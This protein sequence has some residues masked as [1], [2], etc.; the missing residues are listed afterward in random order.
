ML[1]LLEGIEE[2]VMYYDASDQG[3]GGVLTQRGMVIA[4]ASRQLKIHEVNYTTHDLETLPVW[5]ISTIFTDHKNIQHTFDHEL[6][7]QR[8]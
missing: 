1:S 6:S 7:Y 5:K 3:L 8:V 2:F 4:Y